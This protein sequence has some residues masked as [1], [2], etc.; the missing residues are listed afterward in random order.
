MWRRKVQI[1][2]VTLGMTLFMSRVLAQPKE[3][4]LRQGDLL[5]SSTGPDAGLQ[6]NWEGCSLL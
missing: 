5:S 3:A 4:K 1:F 2:R 6:A